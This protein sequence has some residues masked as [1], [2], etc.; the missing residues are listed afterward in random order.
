[1]ILEFFRNEARSLRSDADAVPLAL[2]MLSS[3]QQ[4]LTT[5][6]E[7]Q[8]R[9]FYTYLPKPEELLTSAKPPKGLSD[10]MKRVLE[11]SIAVQR[12]GSR[13]SL[14]EKLK[15]VLSGL[16]AT[17]EM[18]DYNVTNMYS[19]VNTF[20]STM[21]SMLVVTLAFLGG[22]VVSTAVILAVFAAI[23]SSFLGLTI[24]PLEFSIPTPL[25]KSYLPLLL[26]APAYLALS[27]IHA[28]LPLTFSLA[29]AGALPAV[30]HYYYIRD[31]IR[32]ILKAR[33]MVRAAARAV[34]NPYHA[35]VKEGLIKDPAD[36]LKP[37]GSLVTAARLALYQIL[38]HGGYGFLEKLEDFYSRIIDFLIQLRSKTRVFMAYAIV[39]AALVSSIYA[40]TVAIK[41]L[42]SEG[43][44]YLAKAGITTAGILELEA[45]ID[46]ILATTA[47]ALSISTSSAREGKP[48]FF[49]M[50]LPLLA[51]VLGLS[52]IATLAAAPSLL[53]P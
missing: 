22:G 10:R 44:E 1:M 42:F 17:L 20:M 48:T 16:K 4:P 32:E 50:Y 53:G 26:F 25:W 6:K 38:L 8:A 2:V 12:S 41:P 49:T 34:G 18:A 23:I 13:E 43:G 7:L 46:Y 47:I 27:Y 5:L 15:D 21:S 28:P 3:P 36:L 35:L 52:Y 37:G 51:A 11:A 31:Q 39:E 24:Y 19:I 45:G 14:E 33:E 30:L 29:I 40:F 9:G